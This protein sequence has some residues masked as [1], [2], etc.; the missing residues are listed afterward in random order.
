M[1]FSALADGVRSSAK[2]APHKAISRGIESDQATCSYS[3]DHSAAQKT[4]ETRFAS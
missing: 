1:R 3:S 4:A 2:P